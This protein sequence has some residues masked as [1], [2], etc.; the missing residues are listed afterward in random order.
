MLLAAGCWQRGEQAVGTAFAEREVAWNLDFVHRNGMIGELYFVEHM[1][2]GVGVLDYDNDGDLDLFFPQGQDLAAV[3]STDPNLGRLFRN[4]LA[5]DHQGR[6]QPE[7]VDVTERSRLRADGY[8]TGVAVGDIDNDGFPDLYLTNFGPNQLWMNRGDGTFEDR[9]IASGTVEHRWSS[10]A[11]FADVDGDGWLDLFVVNYVDFR[12]ATHRPCL[13]PDGISDYCSPARYEP[14][15]DRLFRNQGDGTFEDWS[16][17]AGIAGR[18]GSGLGVVAAD[19][20]RDGSVDFYVANDL[21][22]NFL[23]QNRGDGTFDEVALLSGSALNRDGMVEASMG[24]AAA[25]F[26]RNG[27]IDLFM[28]HLGGESNTLFVN[29]GSGLFQ[30]RASQSGLALPSLLRT[31]FGTL[32]ADFDHDGWLD[33]VVVNG[34]VTVL[35]DQVQSGSPLPLSEPN[36]LFWNRAGVFEES[37]SEPSL[38]REEVSRGAGLGDFDLDG[39]ADIVLANNG[40]PARLLENLL[41]RDSRWLAVRLR[42]ASTSAAVVGASVSIAS[43]PPILRYV[44]GSGSYCSANDLTAML[45]L[46]DASGDL[47]IDGPGRRRRVLR[48]PR[49]GRLYVVPV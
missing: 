39:D 9:T 20:D 44:T 11:A 49:A 33:L 46:G 30:D 31:G 6:S 23:W 47:V 12:L 7:F 1:G 8:G 29:D 18:A 43:T 3:P 28:T 19:F 42:D 25:D 40:G 35:A 26:D 14:E 27:T 32:A 16:G 17:P 4:D 5:L 48:S 38:R 22:P 34:A 2:P 24:I 15:V 10:S 21:M 13:R 41:G 37:L 45:G 36:Q